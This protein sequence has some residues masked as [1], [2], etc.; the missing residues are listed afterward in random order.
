MRYC[1]DVR[2][3]AKTQPVAL[4][5]WLA[6]L[7]WAFLAVALGAFT[8]WLLSIGSVGADIAN[9]LALPVAV[10]AFV[11]PLA[12]KTLRAVLGAIQRDPK[13]KLMTAIIVT[14]VVVIVGCILTWF[15]VSRADI[16][17]TSDL[18]LINARGMGNGSKATIDGGDRLNPPQRSHLAITLSVH[19]PLPIGDCVGPAQLAVG[20]VVDGEPLR[21]DNDVIRSGKEV[22]LDLDS[23]TRTVQIVV[24]LQ[25]SDL[26]C[27]VDLVIDRAI[28]FA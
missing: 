10:V 23:V 25:E 15:Y 9:I 8:V 22:R 5:R 27:A 12:N 18:K 17:V 16:N 20:L 26:A 2:R 14:L 11:A 6:L 7:A 19:N 28:L 4:T 1:R 24:I 3:H 21:L 13:P